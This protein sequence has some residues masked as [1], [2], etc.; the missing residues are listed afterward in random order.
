MATNDPSNIFALLEIGMVIIGNIDENG[1]L[2][3]LIED[4]ATEVDASVESVEEVLKLIQKFDPTG[5]GARDL[6]ECLLIQVQ[7]LAVQEPLLEKI[8]TGHLKD[9]EDKK[10]KTV[11]KS[12]KVPLEEVIRVVKIIECLEPQ[13]Q[14]QSQ[15]YQN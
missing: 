12:L 11:A 8:I 5:V 1:Y 14:T 4:I 7:E 15:N 9:I 13:P 6:K 10:F 2:K 3:I